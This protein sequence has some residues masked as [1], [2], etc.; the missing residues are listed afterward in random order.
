MRLLAAGVGVAR[1]ASDLTRYHGKM[2]I[3]D[4]SE[5]SVLGFQFHTFGYRS[6]SQL[7]R[8][9]EQPAVGAGSR[10]IV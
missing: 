6:Q 8:Y 5:L 4:R 10:Q 2:L 9:H 1:T 7:R 3:I